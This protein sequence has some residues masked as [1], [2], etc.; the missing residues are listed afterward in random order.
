MI[1]FVVHHATTVLLSVAAI[2]W[3]GFL[4][5]SSLPRESA[6]DIE[7]PFVIVSTPYIGVSPADVESLVTI[8]MERELAS[9]TDVK[10]MTSSSAEGVSIVAI[11]FEPEADLDSSLQKVR[12][13]VSRARPNL[14]DDVEEPSVNEV[15]FS[16]IPIMLIT[17][18]GDVDEQLLKKLAE[19]LQDEVTRVAGVLDA[20]VTGG[21]EREIRVDVLPH[22]L[23]HYG[24]SLNDVVSAVNGENV[25]IPGGDVTT[26]RATFLL[27][28]PGEFTDPHQIEGVAIKRVGDRP[29][30][31]S[32]I[33]RVTD[34][35]EDRTTYSRMDGKPSV[36]VSVKKRAG[37]NMLEIADAVRAVVAEQSATWPPGVTY[38][39][40]GD[41]S[42][43]VD[44][45]VN[46]LQ[47]NIITALLLV[48]GV[49]M[50]FMGVRNSMLVAFAIPMSMMA[51]FLAIQGLGYTLNMVVLFAL[52][53]ALGMLVDNGIVVVE[54]IYRHLEMGKSRIDAAIDGTNEVA[55]AVTASTATTVAAFFPMVFWTGIMGGF[56]GY[57]PKTV[58]IVL[59][60]SLLV[61]LFALPVVAAQ[62]MVATV[63][64]DADDDDKPIDTEA[65]SGTMRG[66]VS[67]L[68]LAIRHRYLSLVGGLVTLIG[69]FVAYGF[70]NHGIE[71]FPATQPDRATVAVR[72][73]EGADLEATDTV[74]R[75]IERILDDVP[76]ID[77]YVAEV[78]V[79]GSGRPI[80]GST[81]AAN[82]AR[83]T[84]DFLPA[85][86]KA[87]DDETPR[88]EP[89]TL[90]MMRIRG[91]VS[92]I[93]GAEITVDQQEMGPPVGDPISVEVAGKDFHEVGAAAQALMRELSHIKG[94]ADLKTDYRVGRPEL[95]L[96]VDRGAA[97]RV[98]VSTQAIGGAIRT[99][100]AGTEASAL[101]DGEDEYDIIVGLA[102]EYRD[103]LQ[104]ILDLRLPGREDTSPSTFPVPLSAVASYEVA[105]GAGTIKHVDQ[106]LVVTITGDVVDKDQEAMVRQEVADFLETW[107]PPH[108]ITASIGGA[109]D[110]QAA[111]AAFLG[112]AFMLAVALILIVL[113]AQFD[114]LT[115]PAIILFTVV[116][117]LVGVLWGLILT[118][119]AFG[120]IMTG[121][122]V[123][124]LAGVVVNNAIVLLDYVEQLRAR[125][126]NTRDA[127]IRA[128]VTRFRPVML[129]ATTTAL[130]LIPMAVGTSIDF[131]KLRLVLGAS[132]AQFWGSMAVAVIFGL[133]FATVLT[134]V[135]V[136]TFYAIL[137]D[138]RRQWRRMRGVEATAVVAKVLVLGLGLAVLAPRP[139]QAVTLEQ[140]QQAAERDNVQV[141]LAAEQTLQAATWRWQAL[142]AVMPRLTAGAT[143]TI[144]QSEQSFD[145]S[146]S[147]ADAF[148]NLDEP[149]R[150]L[151]GDAFDGLSGEPIVVQPKDAWTANFSI[152]QP[153]L[154]GQAFPAY[155][156]AVKQYEAAVH[157]EQRARRRVRGGVAQAYY[158]LVNAR[159]MLAVADDNRALAERQL[160]LARKQVEVGYA[161]KLA[162]LQAQLGV[163][164]AERDVI[165]ARQGIVQ[166]EQ[167]FSRLTGLPADVT[168]DTPP[169]VV[170]PDALATAMSSARE[171]RD[172][173]AAA[174]L[175]VKAASHERTARDLE[176]MPSVDFT[177]TE[178][179]NQVPGFVPENWQWRIGFN[180]NWTLW[181]GGL[182]IARSRELK[183]RVRAAQLMV[184]D[185]EDQA[186]E[187]VRLA[188]ERV[189]AAEESLRAVRAQASL[190][191]EAVKAA[192]ARFGAGRIQFLDVEQAR[193]Q[194]QVARVQELV[195]QNRRD[196]AAID[197]LV[198]M[199]V[200]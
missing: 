154:S 150:S 53:L 88:V 103:D 69:S 79:S 23:A 164:Q 73:P 17:L 194:L 125:G 160:A 113:V 51:S 104:K 37:S 189:L 193:V 115:M 81:N 200:Y 117:S 141:Q 43:N 38:A 126:M 102:P 98:G 19:D 101:R 121:I 8:P 119:T 163:A 123:I 48:V 27:R 12:D 170:I 65:L 30:F 171:H 151:I 122:G 42:E 157:D 168:L 31:V 107:T 91:A 18:A 183:S 139:A 28:T 180:F 85:P 49:L 172:D 78:G 16:D 71:F 169:P 90:T 195:E 165:N 132:S 188:W 3:F 57:L 59:T 47:N 33:A 14:P 152:Y 2:F 179:Y 166:A 134:L 34:G 77:T 176:W 39:V 162:D 131:L 177:F 50:V 133:T 99:A 198:A 184:Q 144:N 1:R 146:S 45:M 100:I 75:A 124:S 173:I 9:L 112:W 135:M 181:D 13:R 41:Q 52:I 156:A 196:L 145:P 6:P 97:K 143:Y 89:T 7:I 138:G 83:I 127:L 192:E 58:I 120:I 86:D 68:D 167:A 10:R 67:V 140:A 11:E 15:S 72:L 175:R 178:I 84:V 128:G 116:L 87:E 137:E 155:R 62:T 190:A 46:D 95:R 82:Q 56:M 25:N 159:Q 199:D 92:L 187:D 20:D 153:L 142:S 80:D 93:P 24:L 130:G 148:D 4:A 64:T 191:D 74:V 108:G 197:V 147:F 105:G 109:A 182:R 35:F 61:A 5:Y 54:N 76:N 114:S 149:I 22:R 94:T 40:L 174:E 186:E 106:D 44:A 63:K 70:L 110:E 96:R 66:Y 21:R 161:D 118:G 129:T 32:D 111:A 55:I 29:V 136:P 60:A 158:S 26:G 36:T 185:A